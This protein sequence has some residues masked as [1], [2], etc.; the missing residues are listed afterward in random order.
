VPLFPLPNVVLLPRAVLPLHVFE[1]RYRAMTADALRGDRRVA[2][3]L[4]RPGWEKNY[5]HKPQIEPVVCVGTI[6]SCEKLA[7]GKYN[8]LLR[9][10]TRARVIREHGDQTY[11]VAELQALEEVEVPEFDLL[12][13]RQ[14]LSRMFAPNIL[15]ATPVGRQFRQ[16]LAGD[17]PTSDVADLVAFNYL[18]DIGLKQS[19]LQDADVA[20][21][22][23][24]VVEALELLR[25]A[26]QVAQLRETHEPGLN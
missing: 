23:R 7:D 10:H 12:P 22:V 5:Y 1:E 14:R 18:E 11:R 20:G 8:F 25:P 19:I 6:V 24:R 3:A 15:G 21:R 9:G 16:L 13:E 17:A 4:L 2:M 26:L